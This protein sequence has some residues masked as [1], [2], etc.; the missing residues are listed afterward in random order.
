MRKLLPL[1]ALLP[2]LVCTRAN[3]AVQCCVNSAASLRAALD[4]LSAG[5]I[6]LRDATRILGPHVDIG[7]YEFD[8]E[9]FA[10]VP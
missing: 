8:A 4:D 6:D 7:A 2:L 9:L 3:A 10:G 1:L 5:L